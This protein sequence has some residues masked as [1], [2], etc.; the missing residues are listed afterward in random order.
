MNLRGKLT[1]SRV[2]VPRLPCQCLLKRPHTPYRA[3]CISARD[4][5]CSHPAPHRGLRIA[6]GYTLP[7]IFFLCL[8]SSFCIRRSTVLCSRSVRLSQLL[9][10]CSVAMREGSA[11]SSFDLPIL[12]SPPSTTKVNCSGSALMCGYSWVQTRKQGFS[13]M[14]SFQAYSSHSRPR[15]L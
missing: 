11:V 3:S 10:P 1:F 8:S 14:C 4:S 5:A 9:S 2:M 12:S 6:A 7:P 13:I 15:F